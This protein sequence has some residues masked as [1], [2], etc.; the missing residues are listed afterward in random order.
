MLLKKKIRKAHL[1]LQ[2]SPGNTRHPRKDVPSAS[3]S[4]SSSLGSHPL[5]QYRRSLV[6]VNSSGARASGPVAASA[7]CLCSD[8]SQL[9][10]LD[11]RGPLWTVSLDQGQAPKR[12]QQAHRHARVLT[13]NCYCCW[14]TSRPRQNLTNSKH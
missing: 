2:A 7:T 4:V 14:G 1:K 6:T 5:Q 13:H 12:L 8:Y 11:T 3:G 9:S 10:G